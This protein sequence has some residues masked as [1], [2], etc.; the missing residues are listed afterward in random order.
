MKEE[1]EKIAGLAMQ[2]AARTGRKD[3]IDYYLR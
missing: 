3:Y 2:L 1:R